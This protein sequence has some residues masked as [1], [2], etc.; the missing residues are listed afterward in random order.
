MSRF[1]NLCLN[2]FFFEERLMDKKKESAKVGKKAG[3]WRFRGKAANKDAAASPKGTKKPSKTP[4]KQAGKAKK[5]SKTVCLHGCSPK[6]TEAML[7]EAFPAV[8]TI[9]FEGRPGSFLRKAVLRFETPEEAQR[10][11]AP[12]VVD[13]GGQRLRVAH[14]GFVPTLRQSKPAERSPEE[15][16][17]SVRLTGLAPGTK[18]ADVTAAF[19]SAKSVNLVHRRD[20]FTRTA[21]LQFK[22]EAEAKETAQKGHVTIEERQLRLDWAGATQEEKERRIADERERTVFLY[23]CPTSLKAFR[24]EFPTAEHLK[25]IEREGKYLGTVAVCFPTKAEA[26]QAAAHAKGKLCKMVRL[27]HR[28]SVEEKTQR[29]AEERT[30]TVFLYGWPPSAKLLLDKFPKA[31]R[32]VEIERNGK[33]TGTVMVLFGTMEDAA[34]FAK[35]NTMGVSGRTVRL[36]LGGQPESAEEK[37][38]R[39]TELTGRTVYLCGCFNN[40]KELK[41]LFPTADQITPIEHNGKFTGRVAVRFPT[42]A[43]AEEVA[44]QGKV[45]IR[46]RTIKL[47]MHGRPSAKQQPQ[48]H[49]VSEATDPK[50][51]PPTQ[52]E[53]ENREPKAQPPAGTESK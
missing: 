43:A 17:R 8:K 31:E 45:E 19:P 7:G 1:T 3:A 42:S 49:G 10:I 44:K 13:V 32:V 26:E 48:G 34:E 12:G 53:V 29:R 39:R 47:E 2:E 5:P 16:A 18:L 35:Q 14:P 15:L 22:T 25:P 37:A 4:A 52:K 20:T 6:I 51:Q 40:V 36:E 21:F 24:E 30:R 23:G 28:E 9:T 41:P 27:G 11:V 33:L 46:G 50:A 38:Q